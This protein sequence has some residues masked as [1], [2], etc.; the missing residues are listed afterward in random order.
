MQMFYISYQI[1]TVYNTVYIV[2]YHIV[3]YIVFNVFIF[4]KNK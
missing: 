4:D 3:Y 2:V 1:I